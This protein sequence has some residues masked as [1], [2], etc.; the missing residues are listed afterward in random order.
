[1]QA[2]RTRLMDVSCQGEA[3]TDSKALKEAMDRQEYC[4]GRKDELDELQKR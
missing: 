3:G 2:Q 1:M 4:L